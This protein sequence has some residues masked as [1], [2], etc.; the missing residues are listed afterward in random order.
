MNTPILDGI[1]KHAA[2]SKVGDMMYT[3]TEHPD[4]PIVSGGIFIGTDSDYERKSKALSKL[5]RKHKSI[6]AT[7]KAYL[8]QYPDDYAS[9][10]FKRMATP[11]DKAM[12][13]FYKEWV[14][15]P[16]VHL[17]VG[18]SGSQDQSEFYDDINRVA[19][20]NEVAKLPKSYLDSLIRARRMP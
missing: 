5:L 17:Y 8:K 10:V 18:R 14:A 16:R 6:Q 13:E 15:R 2:I 9:V 4:A 7:R 3:D 11:K 12:S 19:Y 1:R 20:E